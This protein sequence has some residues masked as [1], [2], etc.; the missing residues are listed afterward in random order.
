MG[1]SHSQESLLYPA[2]H[3]IYSIADCGSVVRQLALVLR[4]DQGSL[5]HVVFSEAFVC[6]VDVKGDV[7]IFVVHL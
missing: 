4:V 6:L 2:A 1:Q 7:A 5:A 3:V